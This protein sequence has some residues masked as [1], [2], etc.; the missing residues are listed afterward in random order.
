MAV[1]GGDFTLGDGTGGE[2]IYGA[3][4]PDENFVLPHDSAG[5]LSMA[6]AGATARSTPEHN[7]G[8][9]SVGQ[10]T[11]SVSMFHLA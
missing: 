2:S 11:V 3:T 9:A 7:T 1:Q 6:N 5:L 8:H 10:L 4:F